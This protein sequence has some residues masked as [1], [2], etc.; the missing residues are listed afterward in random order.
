MSCPICGGNR[1]QKISSDLDVLINQSNL[2]SEDVNPGGRDLVFE[3]KGRIQLSNECNA[4]DH[5]LLTN[6]LKGRE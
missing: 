3:K 2:I 5:L 1:S 4:C 6:F